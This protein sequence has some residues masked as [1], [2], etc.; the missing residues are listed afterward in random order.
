MRG[1]PLEVNGSSRGRRRLVVRVVRG[2]V[3]APDAGRRRTAC[4]RMLLPVGAIPTPVASN[5]IRASAGA[6]VINNAGYSHIISTDKEK[7][8]TGEE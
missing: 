5:R 8:S 7:N 6:H 1:D 2:D 3:V 4:D